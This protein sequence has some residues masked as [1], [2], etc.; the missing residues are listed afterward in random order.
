MGATIPAQGGSGESPPAPLGQWRAAEER[1]YPVVLTRPDLYERAVRLVRQVTDELMACRD[2]PA[3]VEAWPQAADIVVRAATLALMPLDEIDAGLVAGA[4]FAMRYRELA[5]EAARADRAARIQ[6]AAAAGGGWVEVDRIGS[7]ETGGMLAHSWVEMHV[8]SGVALRRSIEPDPQTGM[9][10]FGLEV[11]R[12][13]P[14][15]GAPVEDP[16]GPVVEET[17][18]DR[19]EWVAA[20]DAHRRQM[21]ERERTGEGGAG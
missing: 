13:D 2:V 1:L 4:A 17:F 20:A 11:V 9:P 15:T 12:R 14:F 10:R 8:P 21:E 3:L 6:A 16:G 5:A 19:A 7:P 18:E